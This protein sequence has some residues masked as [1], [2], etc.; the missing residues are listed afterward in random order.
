[1]KKYILLVS[2][3][4]TMGITAWANSHIST[5]SHND[6]IN[7]IIISTSQNDFDSYFY[8]VGDDGFVIKWS[9]DGQGEHYQITEVPI[10]KIACSPANDYIAVYESD[11]GTINKISVWD[12]KTLKKKYQKQFNDSITA[13]Q[14]SAKGTYLIV[15]TA[16]VDGV[17]FYNT[18]TGNEIN[19]IKDNTGVVTHIITSNSE[20]TA[21]FYS[22]AGYVSYYNTQTGELKR[23]LQVER[24]LSQPIIYN[25]S[26]YLAGEKDG[27]IYII[28]LN[29][30]STVTSV[31]AYDPVFLSTKADNNLYY[32]EYLGKGTYQIKVIETQKSSAV[33]SPTVVKKVYGPKRSILNVGTKDESYFY[34]GNKAGDIYK[35]NVDSAAIT[36]DLIEVTEDTYS[37]IYGMVPADSDFYFL[38]ESSIYKSS[39]DA[40]IVEK[41]ASTNGETNISEYKENSVIL[42]TKNSKSPVILMDLENNSSKR[43]FTPANYIQSLRYCTIGNKNYI[44]YIEG[45]STVNLYDI[46]TNKKRQIYSG[47]GVQDAV[48]AHNG[49]IYVAKSAATNPKKPILSIDIETLETVPVTKVDGD[50]VYGLSTD[51]TVIYGIRLVPDGETFSTYVFSY[52]TLTEEVKNI[53]KFSNE[54]SEAFTYLSG[55]YLFTNIGKNKIFCYNLSTKKPFSYNRSAS[56]PESICKNGD[57]V[58]I[59]NYNGSISWAT[60]QNGALITDWYLTKDEQWREF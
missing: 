60:V 46:D 34:F 54:D 32:M 8:S 7:D 18:L 49:N 20:K 31:N 2:L 11:G 33:S 1:M 27:K 21:V 16:S 24:N 23:K 58:V 39:Y 29:T 42:W 19:K 56:M 41:V 5:Q 17:K 45:S 9:S 35:T 48:L 30:G 28:N 57:K 26:L 13:L 40:S 25:N 36:D 43:L 55:S 59:Q 22:P 37:R 47:T 53:L 15:G 50:I 12:W 10:K 3:I 38:T 4:F 51:G 14:F 44:L 52:H 6:Q